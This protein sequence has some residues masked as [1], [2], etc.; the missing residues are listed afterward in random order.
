MRVKTE[1]CRGVAQP[2]SAS[3]LE[4]GGCRFESCRLDSRH[5]A[6]LDRAPH[7]GC[8]GW[9][10]KPSRADSGTWPS[11][12]G[13]LLRMQIEKCGL[14]GDRRVKLAFWRR[15]RRPGTHPASP[16][17]RAGSLRPSTMERTAT[18]RGPAGAPVTVA[19]AQVRIL[20]PRQIS[21]TLIGASENEQRDVAQSGESACSGS[22]RSQVQILSSRFLFWSARVLKLA[23]NRPR[24]GRAHECVRV[25]IPPW[26]FFA[27]QTLTAAQVVKLVDT[28]A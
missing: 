13:R 14:R 1:S 4:P 3:G 12:V 6:Q 18:G 5:V 20:P 25:R 27:R 28:R 22:T 9:R 17:L 21:N 10:F 7:Y 8:G 23:D 16:A 11:L 19:G 26:A 2:G 15:G 24:D